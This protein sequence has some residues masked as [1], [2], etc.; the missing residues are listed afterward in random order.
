MNYSLSQ[1]NIVTASRCGYPRHPV[2]DV[3][4]MRLLVVILTL[5]AVAKVATLQ[6]L[7]RAA[8]DDV[9]ISAYRPRALDACASEARRVALPTETAAWS[10]DTPIRLEIG[11]RMRGVAVW[12][13]DNSNWPERFRNPY[14]HLE[15]VGSRPRVRCEYDIV[16][17]TAATSRL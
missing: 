5:C 13:V 12:Q 14:L 10:A 1:A 6:W 9:I 17:G 3:A 2:K 7:H 8:S 4:T 11:R 16:N 15:T